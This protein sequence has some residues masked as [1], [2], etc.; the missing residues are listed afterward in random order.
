MSMTPAFRAT[1]ELV[2]MVP[3]EGNEV[4]SHPRNG[5]SRGAQM[6]N[7]DAGYHIHTPD[8]WARAVASLALDEAIK[9]GGLGPDK[10]PVNVGAKLTVQVAPECHIICVIINGVRICYCV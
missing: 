5:I 10:P 7:E 6:M 2:G 1:R 9:A 3:H 8:S 4:I